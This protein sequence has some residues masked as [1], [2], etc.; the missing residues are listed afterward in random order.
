MTWRT[1]EDTVIWRRELY[2]ALCGGIV[3]EEALDLS[4]DRTLN[5]WT[6][7]LCT[8]E[9]RQ[10]FPLFQLTVRLTSVVDNRTAQRDC[11]HSATI[12]SLFR[13]KN[14]KWHNYTS[15][16][17]NY[18]LVGGRFQFCL[19]SI[20]SSHNSSPQSALSIHSQHVLLPSPFRQHLE[21][22]PPPIQSVPV[23]VPGVKRPGVQLTADLH[24]VRG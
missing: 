14:M 10:L 11:L 19:S 16:Y 1:G 22:N 2:V 21:P 17:I 12:Q 3:L 13:R 8:N 24:L 20:S 4:S 23:I 7:F 5:E 6:I 9:Y 18:P 15:Y